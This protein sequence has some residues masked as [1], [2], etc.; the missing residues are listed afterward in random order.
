[1]FTAVAEDTDGSY[2]DGACKGSMIG[3]VDRR[4]VVR[5]MQRIAGTQKVEGIDLQA[6]DDGLILCLVTD[7]DTPARASALLLARWKNP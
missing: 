3:I 7:A 2:V 4:G 6:T 5:A 1:M